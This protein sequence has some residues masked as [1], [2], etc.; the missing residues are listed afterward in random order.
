MRIA[1][2]LIER[3]LV[4][5]ALY[6]SPESLAQ[7][8][9]LAA[10]RRLAGEDLDG[11]VLHQWNWR[12]GH[13]PLAVEFRFTGPSER[14]NNTDRLFVE[15]VDQQG[16]VRAGQWVTG[17]DESFEIRV[18]QIWSGGNKNLGA[19]LKGRTPEVRYGAL[20]KNILKAIQ[21]YDPNAAAT[22][23]GY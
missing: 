23:G 16:T 11:W 15:F 14:R 1:D 9:I 4:E 13:Y 12:G 7:E 10:G 21:P 19:F 20:L 6:G 17:D 8:E 18:K 2:Y 5:I 3:R 22:H